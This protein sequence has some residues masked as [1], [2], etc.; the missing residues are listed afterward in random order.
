VAETVKEK[1]HLTW[2]I[3]HAG[4]AGVTAAWRIAEIQ[5]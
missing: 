4:E 1:S 3:L 2:K 5:Q